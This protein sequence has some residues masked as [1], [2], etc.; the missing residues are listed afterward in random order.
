MK[1]SFVRA[2][3]GI[4][5]LDYEMTQAYLRYAAGLA[6]LGYLSYH[7]IEASMGYRECW[8]LRIA[9]VLIPVPILFFPRQGKMHWARILYWEFTGCFLLPFAQTYLALLNKP[10]A[11]WANSLL[12]SGLFL[13]LLTKPL[14]FIPQLAIGTMAAYGLHTVLRGAPD[15]ETL[16]TLL[17]LQAN[18]CL[19]GVLAL[20]I[21]TGIQAFHRRG[22]ALA[23]ANVRAEEA[24]KNEEEIRA[25]NAELR[26]RETVITRFLRPSLFE[27]LAN[28]KDPTEF[29][30]VEKDLGILFCDI[31]DFTHLTEI[32][33]P[34]GKQTFLNQYF[35]MMTH[36]IVGNGGEV[37]KIMGDC[38]MGLFPDGRTA[39]LAA[40][41]MRLS[42]QDFNRKMFLEEKPK[43]R[44][45]IGI[46]K[47]R[48]MMGNFGSYEK[49][50]RTVIGEAVNIASRL[51]SKTKMYNL[52]VVVTEDV[53]KDLDPAE[54]HWRWIDVVQ[55]KG[56]SRH[57]RIYEVYSHQPAEVRKYKD[58]SREMMEKALTIYFQKGFG[59]AIRI[60]NAL[61]KEVPPHRHSPDDLMDPILN[62]YIDRCNAWVNDESGSLERLEK[63]QGV[64]IFHEK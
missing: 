41:D 59:D 44:N 53:I 63:W 5:H 14:W 6:G 45:G 46:A 17:G 20:A 54:T 38:V 3:R 24:K 61:L 29:E 32:L 57:L 25:A 60:F 34:R 51:E 4:F 36:S 18:A 23:E 50:D 30:P 35:S 55:V 58:G 47:G 56:S 13:G 19:A 26:R 15:S 62:Y 22:R 49:L 16:K 33:G 12:L 28:G 39:A 52:E 11:Y 8:P 2:L 37:D 64:H 43:I 31:R 1:N 27:E 42:L 48:V 7:F 10:D 21:Q 9:C 40:V